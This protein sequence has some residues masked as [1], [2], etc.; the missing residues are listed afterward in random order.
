MNLER[1]LAGRL[2]AGFTAVA[3]EPVDPAV[4]R[5][6]HADFQSDAALPVAHR[7]GR[8][9]RDVAVD[10]LSRVDLGGLCSA[11]QVSGPGFI[12]LTVAPDALGAML[13]GMVAD[14][15]HR[16]GRSVAR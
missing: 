5:S 16:V 10:V 2:A 1:L 7:L 12:N 15:G 14:V 6:A 4:R 3:G 13:C 9:P 11:V 8:P